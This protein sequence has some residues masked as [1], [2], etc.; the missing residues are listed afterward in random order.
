MADSGQRPTAGSLSSA[1]HTLIDDILGMLEDMTV[2]KIDITSEQRYFNILLLEMP[3]VPEEVSAERLR[4]VMARLQTKSEQISPHNASNAAPAAPSAQEEA[5]LVSA[6]RMRR[7]CAAVFKF[8][9]IM[10]AMQPRLASVPVQPRHCRQRPLA[11][12]MV[13]MKMNN[14]AESTVEPV[15]LPQLPV[16]LLCERRHG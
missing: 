14:R 11:T 10:P 7:L 2:R 16:F 12:D 13:K 6:E 1:V 8:R 9:R 4:R 5:R 15:Q 3:N